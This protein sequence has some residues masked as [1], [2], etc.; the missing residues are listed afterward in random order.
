MWLKIN[1][2][3]SSNKYINP[4]MK[5]WK[6]NEFMVWPSMGRDDKCKHPIDTANTGGM[7]RDHLLF[8][9]FFNLD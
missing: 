2:Y 1:A 4:I 7:K 6:N 5:Y 8:F 3:F 9:F